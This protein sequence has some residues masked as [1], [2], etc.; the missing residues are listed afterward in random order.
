MSQ[1]S[2]CPRQKISK[3]KNG[4]ED[5]ILKKGLGGIIIYG[6]P[7][8]K[9]QYIGSGMVTCPSLKLDAATTLEDEERRRR[10]KIIYTLNGR[11]VCVN[12]FATVETG[13]SHWNNFM[14]MQIFF[15]FPPLSS[16]RISVFVYQSCFRRR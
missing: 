5:G 14:I 13:K 10:V 2:E 8:R 4:L 11:T 15:S 12:V 6:D 1:M 7:V 3:E 16:A 9:F